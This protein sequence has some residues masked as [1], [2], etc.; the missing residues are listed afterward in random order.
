M[1]NT[2]YHNFLRISI[3]TVSYN[4]VRFLEDNILSVISQNYANLEHIIIDAGSTDGTLDILKKYDKYIKWISEPD[5]G[6]SQGL[7]KGFKMA[8]GEIIGWINSDDRLASNSLR[9]V[10]QFFNENTDELAVVGDQAIIDEN[11]VIQ[12]IIKSRS[13]DFSYLV[14]IA[15]GITQ[16]SIFFKREVF[17]KIGYINENLEYAMDRDFF[18]RLTSIKDI[19]Y[20]PVTLAE[21]RLQSNSKTSRGSFNF[22]KE[23]IKIRRNYGSRLFSPGI[24][25]DLYIIFSEPLRRIHWFRKFIQKLRG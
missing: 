14:N 1:Q 18:I 10:S 17:N 13:Y 19:P 6:Q 3:I 5:G 7:N 22:A 15:R 2:G 20:I 8:T 12:K 23:L 21:F 24:K 11:G 16:N 25:N 9:I 4:Q